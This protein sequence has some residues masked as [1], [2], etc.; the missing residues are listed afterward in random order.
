MRRRVD[1]SPECPEV[2]GWAGAEVMAAQVGVVVL[3]VAATV[4][5]AMAV[6]G[7]VA[8]MEAV[9]RGAVERAREACLHVVAVGRLRVIG[10]THGL[11][12]RL[13]D[14]GSVR[15]TFQPAYVGAPQRLWRDLFTGPALEHCFDL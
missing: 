14:F 13:K 5:T 8:V 4:A 1:R 3:G 7:M 12:R 11:R 6:G 15:S 10:V 2:E 9:A